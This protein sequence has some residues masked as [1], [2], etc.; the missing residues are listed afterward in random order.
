MNIYTNPPSLIEKNDDL[1]ALLA[2][3]DKEIQE[4]EEILSNV[5]KEED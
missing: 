4:I 3:V 2:E 1:K 5:N